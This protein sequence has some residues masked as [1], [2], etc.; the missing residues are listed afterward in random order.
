MTL[1]L[2]ACVPLLG[3]V[4]VSCSS[5]IR[6]VSD[7]E[8]PWRVV[9]SA[10][11]QRLVEFVYRPFFAVQSIH[12]AGEFNDWT[13]PG[14]G[15]GRMHEMAWDPAREYWVYRIWLKSGA[16][17]YVY[18]ADGKTAVADLKNMIVMPDG[19]EVS[20]MVVR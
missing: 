3:L 4:L 8:L 18:I 5:F 12:F 10:G 15:S 17:H 14:H 2:R 9:A 13:W 20:R 11:E 16:W 6:D 19:T 7:V 1:L